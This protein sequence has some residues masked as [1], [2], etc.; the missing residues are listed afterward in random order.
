MRDQAHLAQNAE[1]WSGDD[2]DLMGGIA[3]IR[4]I[5]DVPT[6]RPPRLLSNGFGDF[7]KDR[8]ILCALGELWEYVENEKLFV[9]TMAGIPPESL[10]PTSPSTTAAGKLPG[11]T[12]S[13]GGR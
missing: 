1:F 2:P 3:P 9:C 5:G 8:E 10:I 13:R 12:I 11:K 4:R 7:R 6:Y